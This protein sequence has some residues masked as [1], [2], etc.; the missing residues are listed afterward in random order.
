MPC[1]LLRE[2]DL[3]GQAPENML[4]CLPLLFV[5]VVVFVV[6]GVVVVVDFLVFCSHISAVIYYL[7]SEF[8]V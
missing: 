8:E 2:W 5:V 6:V 1:G 4:L 7:T 3:S